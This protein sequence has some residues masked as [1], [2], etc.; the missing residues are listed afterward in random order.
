MNKYFFRF[1]VVFFFFMI[2]CVKYFIFKESV[3]LWFC[4]NERNGASCSISGMIHEENKE[5]ER[6]KKY[7]SMSCDY[8]YGI[9][10]YKLSKLIIFQREIDSKEDAFKYLKKACNLEHELSCQKMS[11]NNER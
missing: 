5:F 7:Y 4:E 3:H 1:L 6:A 10:C 8:K 9:G 2:V 11:G